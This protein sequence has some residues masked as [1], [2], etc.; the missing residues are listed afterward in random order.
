[1]FFQCFGKFTH[2]K[3]PDELLYHCNLPGAWKIWTLITYSSFQCCFFICLFLNCYLPM[4]IHNKTK[5]QKFQRVWY[6][7]IFIHIPIYT[8]KLVYIKSWMEFTCSYLME[9]WH[10]G[11]MPFMKKNLRDFKG[12]SQHFWHL[13]LL[14]L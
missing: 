10:F 5:K 12:S 4:S 7:Y 9:M 14:L 8:H 2:C 11:M 3:T 1:M 13:L 6:T